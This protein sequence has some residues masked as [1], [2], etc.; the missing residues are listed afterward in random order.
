MV[1]INSI[2]LYHH[3]NNLQE[4]PFKVNDSYF[5]FN[6]SKSIIRILQDSNLECRDISIELLPHWAKC[7]NLLDDKY[8]RI[9]NQEETETLKRYR[10]CIFII[11]LELMKRYLDILHQHRY[12]ILEG[13]LGELIFHRFI[14][15]KLLDKEIDSYWHLLQRLI[16]SYNETS[17][18]HSEWFRSKL[19]SLSDRYIERFYLYCSF[20][21][22]SVKTLQLCFPTRI[23]D[24]IEETLIDIN[25]Y[26]TFEQPVERLSFQKREYSVNDPQLGSVIFNVGMIKL[27][28]VPVK[29]GKEVIT[30]AFLS[31]YKIKEPVES[32]LTLK[33]KSV[34]DITLRVKKKRHYEVPVS[35]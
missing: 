6:F 25:T 22:Q 14:K 4:H 7:I 9:E 35:C 10:S 11:R 19:K 34:N 32:K 28:Y 12:I 3:L 29:Q 24:I 5:H 1:K 26:F 18:Q 21:L 27:N 2:N 8:H 30:P 31:D 16:I 17:E 13:T 23:L 20:I 33:T 15:V